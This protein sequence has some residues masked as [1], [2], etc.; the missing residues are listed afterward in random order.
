MTEQLSLFFPM[1]NEAG[2]IERAVASAL[3]VLPRV[4]REFEVIV[5]DDGSA[6][7]TAELGQALADRDPRV[8]LVRHPVNRGYGAAV[9]SGFEAAR[10]SLVFFTDG[11]NQFDLEE[12]PLVI[13]ALGELDGVS[14]FRILRRDPPHRRLNSFLYNRLAR[15]LFDIP[16]RDVNC[17]FKVYRKRI[18]DPVLP[19]LGSTGALINVEMLARMR[20]RKARFGE[21]G[22]HH[23][24]REVGTQTGAKL[25]VIYRAFAD[26]FRLWRELR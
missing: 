14:G 25:G 26:L 8:R 11:D 13:D 23:F 18:L 6:D 10:Y 12:L 16:I 15:I 21:V 17:A 2:N 1:Y 19:E 24:P 5:V 7:R 22:V 9:R 3:A 20:K 4:A